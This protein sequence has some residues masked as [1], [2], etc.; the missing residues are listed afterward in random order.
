MPKYY[1]GTSG[2]VYPHWREVFYPQ[3]LAQPK[4]LEFYTRHFSTV[5]LNNSFYHLPTEK[6]FSNWYDTSPEGFC[7]AVKVSRFITHIKRLKDVAEPIETFLKRARH[8]RQKLGPLLY[9]LPPNMHRNDERLESFLSLLPKGLRH[10]IEFR[11]ESWLDE[12]VFDI[13]RRH[14]IGFCVFDMP[15]LPCPLLA[16]AD[17]A[18]VRFHGSSGLYSS[19]YSDEELEGWARRISGLAKDLEAVYIYFNNDAEGFAIKNAQTLAKYL[20]GIV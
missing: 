18:Y 15:G 10:V 19:C 3:K 13:L 12:G 2:W 14:N 20:S 6:A 11:H 4:W 17:F 16:T 7:Y 9:Q 8:L 1:I 5:E